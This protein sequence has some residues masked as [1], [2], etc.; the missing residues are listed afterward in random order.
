MSYKRPI[1]RRLAILKPKNFP[2]NSCLIA[3][4][5]F[6]LI[7]CIITLIYNIRICFQNYF[8]QFFLSEVDFR[9]K[10]TYITIETSVK[11][12]FEGYNVL[13]TRVVF[14]EENTYGLEYNFDFCLP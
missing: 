11:F 4:S 13:V 1:S 3:Q 7:E 9:V 5:N 6:R 2:M 14:I 12:D 10:L 8:L